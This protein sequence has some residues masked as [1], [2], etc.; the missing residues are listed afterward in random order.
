MV[1]NSFHAVS[2]GV[3][4]EPVVDRNTGHLFEKR[5]VHKYVQARAQSARIDETETFDFI[6]C[7]S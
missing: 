2:G 1:N 7:D 6:F 5:L 3:P 4:E